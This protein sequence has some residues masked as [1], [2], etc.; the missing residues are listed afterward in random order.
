YVSADRVVKPPFTIGWKTRVWSTFKAPMIVA[1]GKVFCGGRLGPLLALDAA[2]GEILWKVHHPGVESRPAPTYVDGRLLLMRTRGNQGDSPYVSGASGGP[3]GEGLWC[4]DAS[5]GR[6]LWHQP[7]RFKYHFNHD[8]LAAHDGKVFV[9]RADEP[10]ALVAAA[11]ALDSGDEVWRVP[12]GELLP[13]PTAPAKPGGPDV[14]TGPS[15]LPPRFSGV[16][17]EGLWCLSVSDRGT[18]A[19][20][21]TSGR[22]VWSDREVFIT[23]RTR[24]AARDGVLVVFTEKGDQALDAKTGRRLWKSAAAQSP[25]SQALTPRYLESQGRQGVYPTAVCAWPVFANGFWYSH[26]NFGKAHGVNGMAALKEPEVEELAALGPQQ[27]AWSFEFLS[28]ACPSPSPAYGRLYYSPNAEGVVYCF[29]PQPA[30]G[31]E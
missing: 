30:A 4:H 12:L 19:L 2:T 13:P 6:K 21:P 14:K 25:Y 1:D 16:M 17:A 5:T 15:W 22:P 28:N 18:A 20:D 11:Y 26:K 10:G 29:V 23:R 31:S 7:M 9:I 24:V 3:P 8:G 27:L